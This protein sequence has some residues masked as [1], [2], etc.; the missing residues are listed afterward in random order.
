LTS[1]S[2]FPKIWWNIRVILK[3]TLFSPCLWASFHLLSSLLVVSA[4][5]RHLIKSQYEMLKLS[6][7]CTRFETNYNSCTD[8]NSEK[9]GSSSGGAQDNGKTG[10]NSVYHQNWWF[11]EF[12]LTLN[13][14]NVLFCRFFILISPC[15]WPN[16]GFWCCVFLTLRITLLSL[17]NPHL[18]PWAEPYNFENCPTPCTLPS[19]HTTKFLSV[20]LHVREYLKRHGVLQISTPEV[21]PR[22]IV[23]AK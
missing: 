12:H 22:G 20:S 19:M 11:S 15:V 8:R 5:Y 4:K 10:W 21:E 16:S 9:I 23:F 7:Y 17:L 1:L 13:A 3:V 6:I 18:P 2:L 14:N